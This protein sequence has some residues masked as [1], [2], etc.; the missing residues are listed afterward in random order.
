MLKAEKGVATDWVKTT[1][2]WHKILVT[3]T[4]EAA[5]LADESLRDSI[6]SAIDSYYPKKSTE[7]IWN[8]AKD[9][10]I[11]FEDE[12]VEKALGFMG[13]NK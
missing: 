12:K 5:L 9:L 4:D 2:G 6:Y 3:E 7:I 10:N 11:T 1:Y 13:V 8:T